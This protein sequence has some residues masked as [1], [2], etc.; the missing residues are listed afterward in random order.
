MKFTVLYLLSLIQ[1]INS[2][3]QCHINNHELKKYAKNCNVNNN[4]NSNDIPLTFQS[5]LSTS[6]LISAAKMSIILSSLRLI[7]PNQVNAAVVGMII[8]YTY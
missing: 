7:L 6:T 8:N 3:H 1:L 4:Y 2:F 5:K